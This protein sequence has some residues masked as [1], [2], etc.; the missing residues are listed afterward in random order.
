MGG[1]IEQAL[2]AAKKEGRLALIP[3]IVGGYPD[4]K[5]FLKIFKTVSGYADAIEIGLPFSDPLADGPVI[6]RA[7]SY[8][9]EENI[10]TD[11]IFALIK[12]VSTDKNPPVV[13]M[14]YYNTVYKYG[15]AKFAKRCA[16]SG[17]SGAIIPDLPVEESESWDKIAAE[18]GLDTIYLVAPTSTKKRQKAVINKSHGFIYCVSVTGITGSRGELPKYMKAYLAGLRGQTKKYLAVGFG[19]SSPEHIKQLKGAADAAVVGSA[20]VKLIDPKS[21]TT[22]NIK[23]ISALLSSLKKASL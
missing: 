23:K 22:A 1:K 4:E 12:D 13:V 17:V 9:L 19:V 16:D 20:L 21:S 7:T 2:S 10:D 18:S 14:T 15:E 8:V 3:Y 5:S 11:K 6:Q